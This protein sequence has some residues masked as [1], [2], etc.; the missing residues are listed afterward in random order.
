MTLTCRAHGLGVVVG[1]LGGR[2]G[3]GRAGLGRAGLGRAGLGRAGLGRA[4]LGRAGLGRAN[5]AT[6]SYR[7]EV[8]DVKG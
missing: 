8:V 1:P 3:L 6:K 4:G 5:R 2:A 7:R